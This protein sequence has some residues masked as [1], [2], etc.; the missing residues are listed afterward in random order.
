VRDK[1][2][3]FV[4]AVA[5]MAVTA[6]SSSVYANDVFV[7]S[8][9]LPYPAEWNHTVLPA[10]DYTFRMVT[11]ETTTKVLLVSGAKQTLDLFVSP[12]WMCKDCSSASLNLMKHGES[13][14]V[15][16]FNLPGFHV[17]FEAPR[18]PREGDKQFAKVQSSEQVAVHVNTN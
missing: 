15:T 8:F 7:G 2:K 18:A 9:T 6:L 16:A 17:K 5:L 11:T 14:V 10:G 12:V 3:L 4:I 13:H 1:S